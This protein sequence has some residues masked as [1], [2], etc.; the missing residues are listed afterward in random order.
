MIHFYKPNTKVTGSACSFYLSDKDGAFFSQFIK[1]ASWNE[2][3]RTGSFAKDDPNKKASIKLT[4]V[5]IAGII[6]ALE[7]DREF[8]AYHQS[9]KQVATFKILP[10]V[11]KITGIRKGF[12]YTLSKSAKDDSTNKLS[13][14]IG[15]TFP[16][17]RRLRQH[18]E[19][20]LN[21]YDYA[22]A[23]SFQDRQFNNA[24]TSTPT[25]TAPKI[26]FKQHNLDD[27]GPPVTSN[28]ND[29]DIW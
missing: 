6:D 12:S 9:E 3:S 10:Y 15:F 26:E 1:Q 11:D 13:F 20:L 25:R 2:K 24:P 7:S 22:K 14:V 27:D 23:E 4:D 21:R 17:A 18:L 16:E 29:G 5:E 8:S 28:Q 19:F